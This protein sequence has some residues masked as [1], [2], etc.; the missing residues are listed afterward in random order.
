MTTTTV[1]CMSKKNRKLNRNC[2][3]G[4]RLALRDAVAHGLERCDVS[5]YTC[6][7]DN[8]LQVVELLQV[9][10]CFKVEY[11]EGCEFD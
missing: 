1:Q 8:I 5:G 2:T 3:V 7:L 10:G 4:W 6:A 11:S 9:R